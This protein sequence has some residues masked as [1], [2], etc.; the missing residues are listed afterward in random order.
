M[1]LASRR[2]L[3]LPSTMTRAEVIEDLEFMAEH[4][5]SFVEAAHRVGKTSEACERFLERQ[6]RNDLYATLRTNDPTVKPTTLPASKTWFKGNGTHLAGCEAA[7]LDA[8]AAH[9]EDDDVDRSRRRAVLAVAIRP[10][11]HA[12]E[13]SA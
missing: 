13:A 7:R 1:T 5:V 10:H 11:P 9:P 8:I 3:R 6:G 2:V 12:M 4:G